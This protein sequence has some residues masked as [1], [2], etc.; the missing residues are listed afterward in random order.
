MGPYVEDAMAR[1]PATLNVGAKKFF[2][3]PESFTPDGSP[4]IGE[5]PELQNYYVAAGLN[6]IGILTGG[7]IGKLVAEWIRNGHPPHDMDITG[8]NIN[9]FHKYQSNPKYRQDRVGEIL[10]ETYKV[11]YPDHN[12]HSCRNV[13]RSPLHDRLKQNNAHFRDVSG[14]ESPSWYAPEGVEPIIEEEHFGKQ[15]FFSYWADEHKAC[16]ENV[17][18]FDMSFMSKFM[19]QGDDAGLFLNRLSTANVDGNCGTITYTQWLNEDGYME[20]DLTVTKLADDTFLVVATDTM[21]NHVLTHMKR[22]LTNQT[23]AFINDV[24][25]SYTQLNIQGPNSRKLLQSLTSYN[26]NNCPFRSS[27]E[28]DIGY[29]TIICTRITYVGEL[30]YE[31]YIPTEFAM[32]VY[33]C[34]VEKGSAFGLKHAGLRALGSLRMEKGYRD[35]GHDIDNTD[36]IL[37]CGLGFTCDFEKA[38]G[39]IGKESI[40]RLKDK[41]KQEGGL[42]KRMVQVLLDDPIY[43]LHHGE[44]LLRNGYPVSDIRS[45]SYGHTL[46]GAVGLSMVVADEPINNAFLESGKWEV[47]IGN[48]LVPCTVSLRQLYDP[49]NKNIH[50]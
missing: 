39:F 36:T 25:A 14:W 48:Q 4:I 43:V 15:S 7:G 17:A 38:G 37:E 44:V 27:V 30:G 1:V 42:K 12:L 3:G 23:H 49:K 32:H 34:I 33:D 50:L 29:A 13:K 10:G 8:I 47:S 45:A 22:R 28:I 31:L 9:R 18:L 26:M 40:L 41:H 20:A 16:R 6:S 2:C 5:A 21:H 35:Y 11:H 46:N 19:V 24:T